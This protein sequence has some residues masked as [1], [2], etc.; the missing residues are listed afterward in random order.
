MNADERPWY[1]ALFDAIG[2]VV[3]ALYALLA[4]LKIVDFD[5]HYPNGER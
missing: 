1:Y 4:Y 3:A 2:W 5:R